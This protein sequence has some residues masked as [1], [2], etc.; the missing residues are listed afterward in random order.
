[1]NIYIKY[2]EELLVFNFIKY[3]YDLNSDD[4]F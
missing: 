4:N 2:K 3:N 1:M